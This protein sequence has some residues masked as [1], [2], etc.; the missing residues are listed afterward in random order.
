MFGGVVEAAGFANPL[1]STAEEVDPDYADMKAVVELLAREAKRNGVA[2]AIGHPHDV[3]LTL[4]SKWLTEDHGVTL[5]P[6]DEA[7][8]IKAERRTKV[9]V[10]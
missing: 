2:I 6:L 8:R 7:M 5:V 3:T 9:A 10:R 4:L 1:T